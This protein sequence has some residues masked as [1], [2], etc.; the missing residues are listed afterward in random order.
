MLATLIDRD[1]IDAESAARGAAAEERIAFEQLAA[2][3]SNDLIN[4]P[5]DDLAVAIERGLRRACDWLGLDGAAFS[6]LSADGAR[7]EVAGWGDVPHSRQTWPPERSLL[8]ASSPDAS[9]AGHLVSVGSV[10]DI[11]SDID[12]HSFQAAGLRSALIA[13]LQVGGQVVGTLCLVAT[14]SRT[15]LVRTTTSSASASSAAVFDQV[16]ERRQREETLR[17][18]LAEVRSLKEELQT[19][20]PVLRKV[21]RAETSSLPGRRKPGGTPGDGADRAGR[22][23]RFDG[24]AARR[25][26][27]RQGSLRVADP[28]ARV[29]AQPADGARELRGDPVD[30][31]R[32]RVVRAGKGRVHRRAGPAGRTLRAGRQG[33]D[34][35][36]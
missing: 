27:H 36:R 11:A 7:L 14:R 35:P 24:A 3:L 6:R 15:A 9:L 29:A 31:D 4:L 22:R 25:D 18:A 13:P 23:H 28:R 26:G 12:R 8:S 16:L 21:R 34:L 10:T 2:E 17:S 5:D 20:N 33:D 32:K 30:A 19:E 1:G